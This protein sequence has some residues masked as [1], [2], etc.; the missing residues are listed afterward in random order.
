MKAKFEQL[1]AIVRDD[2]AVASVVGFTGGRQTNVGFAFM[3]LK[4]YAER[5]VTADE[6]VNRLRGKAQVPGARLFMFTG[7]DLRTGGRQSNAAYQFTLLSDDTAE[8]YKWTP[9]LTEAL[10][11]NDVIK[12][13]NSDQQQGGLETNVEIDATYGYASGADPQRHR[14]HA[15]RRVRSAAGV[16]HLQRTEPISCGHGGRAPLLAGSSHARRTLRLDRR[17]QSDRHPADGHRRGVV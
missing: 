4:P 9:K 5:K 7:S 13:V 14:Q 15:L 6:V 1:L 16:G 10:M 11:N 2:P 12:D 8:L 3:S 17:R